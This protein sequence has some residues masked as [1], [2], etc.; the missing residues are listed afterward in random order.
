ML[1]KKMFN[2][3]INI[4]TCKRSKVNLYYLIYYL[5]SHILRL[6]MGKNKITKNH[7][8]I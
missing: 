8:Q 3:I 5:K 2:K 6:K 1:I 4:F 7:Q